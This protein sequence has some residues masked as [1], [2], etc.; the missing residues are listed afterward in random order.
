M[1]TWALQSG[2]PSSNILVADARLAKVDYANDQ[3]WEL[4][5]GTGDPAA[6][7][8]Q[9]NYGLRAR[10]MRIYFRFGEGDKTISDVREFHSPVTIKRFYPNYILLGFSPFAGIEITAEY[11]VPES[12]VVAG[13]LQLMNQGIALHRI[14]F[15][16]AAW[17]DPASGGLPISPEKREG[18]NILSGTTDGISPVVF[19]TG[20][21]EGRSSPYTALVHH[22]DLQPGKSRRLTWVHAALPNVE[23]SFNLARSTAARNWDAEISRVE[24]QNS[25]RLEIITGDPD[26]DAAFA[27]GQKVA[28]SLIHNSS[29]ALPYASFVET[30]QPDQG[31][32]RKGDGSDYNHLWNGQAPLDAWYICNLLLPG[33]P[34]IAK[35]LLQNFLAIQAKDGRID[36]KPGLAGQRARTSA[37]PIL[38]SLAWR[39][40]LHT[41]DHSFL[42][43]VFPK[44]LAFLHT[45]FGK[46]QDRDRDGL[47]EWDNSVQSGFEDNPAFARWHV[48]SQGADIRLYEDPALCAFLYREIQV[49]KQIADVLDRR[50]ATAALEAISG[51]LHSA[52]ENSWDSRTA[53]YHYW[54]RESHLSQRGEILGKRKGPGEIKVD[55]AFDA[56][57]RILIR[58]ET[59]GESTVSAKM[60]IHGKTASGK[61][62]VARIGRQNIQWFPGLGIATVNQLYSEI[63]RVWIEGIPPNGKVSVRLVDH[64]SQDHTLLLPLWAGIPD[65]ETAQKLIRRSITNPKRYWREYGLPAC[66]TPPKHKDAQICSAV[67]NTWNVLIAEGLLAYDARNEAADLVIKMMRGITH[68]LKTE[69]TFRKHQHADSGESLGERNALAGL[70]PLG[71]FMATLGV[72]IIS[73]WRVALD[74]SNPYT[75]PVT[76][77]FRG[78][79]IEKTKDETTITFP[80]GEIVIVDHPDACIV[81]GHSQEF[82]Q[83]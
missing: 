37:T 69:G 5:I 19:L 66:P 65:K 59:A 70:P 16:L 7:L 45:W 78:L 26:W 42:E 29:E 57:S 9:T 10:N 55:K 82:H 11:W 62:R 6:I 41:E 27:L 36:G 80:N 68:T 31:Y 53:S 28:L 3:I 24:M 39:I 17:L 58:I 61:K 32:S 51:N 73:P 74:G 33:E 71:L 63:E 12:H 22:L 49:I 21:P 81:D 23:D 54:D 44:L 14:R 75:W 34:E 38:A 52:V 8:L 47:P 40:Y 18:A 48:W 76:I 43:S 79:I 77:K 15:E 60:S 50:E 56:P 30:R 67:W 13:R 46:D 20:G 2:D 64:Y 83:K 1:R 4:L 25:S 72:R 35:G